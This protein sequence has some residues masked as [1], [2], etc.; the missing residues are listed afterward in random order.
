MNKNT[1]AIIGAS[2]AGSAAANLLYRLGLD[3]TVFEKRKK[4]TMTD[5]GTGLALPKEL[6]HQLIERDLFDND[7]L[8]HGIKERAF[9]TLDNSAD[10]SAREVTTQPFNVYLQ[11]WSSIYTNLAKRIPDSI[12]N[13]DAAVKHISHANNKI[14]LNLNGKI[15]E[16][17]TVICADG[18]DSIGRKYLF[19]ESELKFTNYIVWRGISNTI[20]T[21][22]ISY[23]ED[24]AP[25]YL[26][27]DGHALFALIPTY[28]KDAEKNGLSITWLVYEKLYDKHPIVLDNI[29]GKNIAPNDMS[30][31]YIEHLHH[32]VDMCL[33]DF[34]KQVVHHT[35]A[36]FI[37]S[38]ND[39]TV[40]SLYKNNI[41]L[42]GDAGFVI[43]PHTASGATKAIQDALHMEKCLKENSDVDAALKA[44]NAACFPSSDNLFQL[45]CSLGKLLVTDVPDCQTLSKEKFDQYWQATIEGRDWY[46]AK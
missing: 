38:I 32:L 31:N 9:I 28:C 39:A 27:P 6:V 36:P 16:F 17:D 3:V 30:Q 15:R 41:A 43:R 42:L 33:P 45:G 10:G 20:S 18:Y 1:V 26:Y 21:E 23:L 4:D 8:K 34:A 46:A 35:D 44:W 12:I 19:P 37:Q 5:R 25:F 14:S 2:I 29:A 40:P 22:Q 13:Y 7:F 11:H 24:R